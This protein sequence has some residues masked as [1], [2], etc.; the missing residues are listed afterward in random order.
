M[1]ALRYIP[2]KPGE[3]KILAYHVMRKYNLTIVQLAKSLNVSTQQV[4]VWLSATPK[5]ELKQYYRGVKV[6]VEANKE[7][8]TEDDIR[9]HLAL[10]PE[11]MRVVHDL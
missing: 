6:C 2:M 1:P 11:Q 5:E 3:W 10:T 4:E 7:H 9:L 8:Y